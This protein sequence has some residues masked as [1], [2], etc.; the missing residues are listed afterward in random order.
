M[1][2]TK[3]RLKF[4]I[5]LAL[6]VSSVQY[7]HAQNV[8][9]DGSSD[10][11]DEV[12]ED[13]NRAAAANP[14]SAPT[15]VYTG[16]DEKVKNTVDDYNRAMATNTGSRPN[17]ADRALDVDSFKPSPP[18]SSF[19]SHATTANGR[20][21]GRMLDAS[22]KSI[23][24]GGA[25]SPENRRAL[26]ELQNLL[27]EN[28]GAASDALEQLAGSQNA[29]LAAAT[30]KGTE[31][32]TAHLLSAMRA[33]PTDTTGEANGRF[34]LQ[35]MGASGRLENQGGSAGLKQGTQ[36]L[37]IGA[38]WAVDH[39]WRAG[40]MGAKTTSDFDA[41]RF[42]AALDSWHLGAYAVRQDGPLALRL[43]AIY[44]SH[45]GNNKR[46]VDVF[47]E[48]AQLKGKYNAQSQ[49]AFGEVGYQVGQGT[50]SAEP[51][52]GLGYQRYH[53]DSF[54]EKGGEAG[55]NVGAQTQENLSSTFGIRLASLHKLDNQMSLTPHLSTSWKHLY[56][57]V[58][59]QVRQSSRWISEM[60]LNGDFTTQGTS[61]DRDSLAMRA[62]LDLGL[63][64]YHTVGLTYNVETGTNSR[65]QGLMGQWTMGF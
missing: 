58:G 4:A 28:P 35:G 48:K 64:Q 56:G 37:L 24:E 40:V 5:A 15:I 34:W 30:Q 23:I 3:Q 33:I 59:S 52:A 45:D 60:G 14:G 1:P 44:S 46:S 47:G 65:N 22:V 12:I 10:N 29:N 16:T 39:A 43:G 8:F 27:L 41:K 51:F 26:L 38:D 49:T 17:L 62:G 42:D 2:F 53:R 6:G 55:L 61:L 31:Q 63:S 54:K 13:Y 20:Q 19:A 9:Y 11:I 7:A 36:G 57:D 18:D 21:V 32:I 50:F 25:G